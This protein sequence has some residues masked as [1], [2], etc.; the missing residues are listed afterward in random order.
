MTYATLTK[1][2]ISVLDYQSLSASDTTGRLVLG[3]SSWFCVIGKTGCN[4]RKR[5]GDL[6]TPIGKWRIQKVFY[7]PDRVPRPVTSLPI[8]ALKQADGWCD[9]VDDRNYNR[10]VRLPYPA[11]CETLWRQDHAY[12]ICIELG[13]NISPRRK[14][15]GSAVF[16]HLA[17]PDRRPTE[18][19]LAASYPDMLQILQRLQQNSFLKVL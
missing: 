12:D 16:F 4:T 2:G 15:L 10:P 14:G 3:Q 13:Y 7:R 8:Q 9:A 18:G 1:A 19:C 6:S 5:E 11:S 17:Q